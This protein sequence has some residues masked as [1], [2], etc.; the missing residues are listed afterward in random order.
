MTSP[1]NSKKRK[2]PD[3]KKETDTTTKEEGPAKSAEEISAPAADA[4]RKD[5]EETPAAEEGQA[6]DSKKSSPVKRGRPRRKK[7][8]SR[9]SDPGKV[10]QATNND[11]TKAN[12]ESSRK[13]GRDDDSGESKEKEEVSVEGTEEVKSPPVKRT[14]RQRGDSSTTAEEKPKGTTAAETKAEALHLKLTQGSSDIKVGDTKDNDGTKTGAEYSPSEKSTRKNEEPQN[15]LEAS[16]GVEASAGKDTPPQNKEVKEI[17]AHT[18]ER[19]EARPSG[20]TGECGEQQKD[21]V[22]VQKYSDNEG[23]EEEES[24]SKKQGRIRKS[25]NAYKPPDNKESYSVNIIRGRG[26]TLG[27][28]PAIRKRVERCSIDAEE[29]KL[30]HRLLFKYRGRIS[31][32]EFKRNILAFNGYL[33]ALHKGEDEEEVEDEDE[34]VEVGFVES[35]LIVYCFNQ[36]KNGSQHTDLLVQT[37]YSVK[38]YKLSLQQISMLLDFFL[39]DRTPEKGVRADKDFLIDKLLDFF[40]APSLGLLTGFKSSQEE[41]PNTP[42]QSPATKSESSLPPKKRKRIE[43]ESSEEEDD[44]NASDDEEKEETYVTHEDW[45]KKA[46]IDGVFFMV[47]NHTK[48]KHPSDAALRQWVQA[49]VTCFDL[50]QA[51][52]KHV[53]QTASAKFGVNMKERIDLIREYLVS[54]I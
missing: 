17:T 35:V 45:A 4:K 1:I 2:M 49:Y 6:E 30:A 10:M 20:D 21:R 54:E 37:Y 9:S 32:R 51:T 28:I 5:P 16:K 3:D 13:R 47:R 24:P 11:S 14:R 15:T 36:S 39:I 25:V 22:H 19:E 27:D 53:I 18:T 43:V 8:V 46:R 23:N 31:Q 26:M 52:L 33:R 41:V 40:S 34:E 12:E 44:H 38:T 50:D 7:S 42:A 29:L 48:G